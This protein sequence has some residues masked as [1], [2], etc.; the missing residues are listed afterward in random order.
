MNFPTPLTPYRWAIELGVVA[1]MAITFSVMWHNHNVKE[2]E[3]GAQRVI[4]A[5]KT[6]TD[7]QKAID[8]KKIKDAGDA[9][10][11][12]IA[13]INAFATGGGDFHVVCRAT[14]P[15]RSVP[16]PGVHDGDSTT[17][18]LVQPDAG[19]HPDIVPALRLLAKRGDVLSA[20]TR[21]L[22]AETH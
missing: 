18:A 5:D 21:Q 3:I 19:V 11:Q 15:P 4:L 1:V 9:H 7:R 2:Q 14:Y 6:A 22:N 13:K 17:A 20:D 8:D 16:A 10:A 12:E